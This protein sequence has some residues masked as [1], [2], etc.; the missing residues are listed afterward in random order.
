MQATKDQVRWRQALREVRGKVR[1]MRLP[2]TQ[3]SLLTRPVT[4][5]RVSLHHYVNNS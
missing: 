5:P 1:T 4:R 2:W 3:V